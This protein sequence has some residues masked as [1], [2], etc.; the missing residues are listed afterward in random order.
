[1]GTL[2]GV[3]MSH[4]HNP[5]QAGKEAV[6]QAMRTGDI[7]TPDFVF[8]FASVGYNQ[9]VLI[10][11]VN[12]ASGGAPL[13]GCS[14]EGI[15]SLGEADESNFSVAT[16]VIQSDELV[17]KNAYATSLKQNSGLCGE[18]IARDL[19][20]CINNETIGMFVFADGLTLNFD[21]FKNA[22]EGNLKLDRFI[23]MF[24]GAAGDNWEMKRTYQYCNSRVI[25]DGAVCTLMSGKAQITWLVSHGCVPIGAEHEITRCE[26]NT[27]YEIDSMPVLEVFKEYLDE[28]EVNNWSRA[29]VNLCLGFKAP[30][31][32][33][34]YDEYLIRFMPTRDDAKGFITISTEAENGT[35]FWMTRRDQEKIANGMRNAASHIKGAIGDRRIKMVFH[36]DC[37]GRGKVVFRDQQKNQLLKELQEK[38]GSSIP[39][40][41]FYTYGEIG[42]VGKQNHFHNYTAIISA[43]Y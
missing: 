34:G 23:P 43:V 15:I 8:M 13:S 18:K 41:G 26:G 29:V 30:A 6:E 33:E 4:H 38:V 22:L 24:G 19:I 39:W 40:I 1:M 35:K 14:G 7:R 37:A 10:D 32:M 12:Q 20:T 2:V 16:M 31:T 27:I 28:E 25:S 21:R 5:K 11:T 42:P 3:G 36:F 17:F 9:Q